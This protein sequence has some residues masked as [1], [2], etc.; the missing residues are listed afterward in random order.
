MNDTKYYIKKAVEIAHSLSHELIDS[1]PS[2]ASGRKAFIDGEDGAA[3]EIKTPVYEAIN[4]YRKQNLVTLASNKSFDNNSSVTV[5]MTDEESDLIDAYCK[6]YGDHA[7]V[8]VTK[9][10]Y[11]FTRFYICKEMLHLF[12]YDNENL[13]ESSSSLKDLITSLIEV[14]ATLD[15]EGS[16]Q[17]S[18]EQAAYYGAVELLIPS[19]YVLPLIN[20][21]D[22][23]IENNIH[24][25]KENYEIAKI[26][27]VPEFIVEFRLNEKHFHWFDLT[28]EES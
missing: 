19:E 6:R 20:T 1:N 27:G 4:S 21:R 18:V 2:Y 13:T 16:P 10:N 15:E 23:M 7:E 8:V 5:T 26:L 3:W 22:Q 28:E 9:N 25:G 12:L 14:N 17:L 11:C 24:Q